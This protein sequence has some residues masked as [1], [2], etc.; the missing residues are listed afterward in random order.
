MMRE[1]DYCRM[2]NR[3]MELDIEQSYKL[4]VSLLMIER[5]SSALVPIYGLC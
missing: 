2:R 4:H 5:Y 1:S 3:T